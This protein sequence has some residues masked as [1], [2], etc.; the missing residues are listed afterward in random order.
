MVMS[1]IQFKVDYKLQYV[2][3][4]SPDLNLP[5]HICKGCWGSD[6]GLEEQETWVLAVNS[7][8]KAG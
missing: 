8:I 2:S 5:W 3:Q 1:N 7:W 4:Y 6:Q